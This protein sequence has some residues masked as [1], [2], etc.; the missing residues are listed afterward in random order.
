M[1]ARP[2]LAA[3]LPLDDKP[4]G[5]AHLIAYLAEAA[6]AL[7]RAGFT[8]IVVDDAG[9]GSAQAFEPYTLTSA[10]AHATDRL[11]FVVRSS[12]VD[13]HPY[14]AAR[15][16]ASLD[17]LSGGRTGWLV[18][19]DPDPARATEY[20]DVVRS[21]WDSWDD[22]AF[23]RDVEGGR[24]YDPAGLHPPEHDGARY[25]VRGPLNIS[26]PPQGHPVIVHDHGVSTT[27]PDLG[28]D[29]VVVATSDHRSRPVDGGATILVRTTS[30][31]VDELVGWQRDGIADGAL[32]EGAWTPD[33]VRELVGLGAAL[34]S[35]AVAEPGCQLRDRL[36]LARPT[37]TDSSISR[38]AS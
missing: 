27:E 11:G 17:H 7:E 33:R 5:I 30:T 20:V 34:G 36:G 24:Y 12:T 14:H 26:R 3:V 21:L 19:G 28:A 8:F 22:D 23:V 15:R 1:S 10:L 38:K 32:V 2:V 37:R 6:V 31:G 35:A 18:G 9:A 29:V 25:R 16:L 13:L 4:A